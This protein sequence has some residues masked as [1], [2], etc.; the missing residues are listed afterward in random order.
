MNF[1]RCTFV[2]AADTAILTLV[3]D[4]DIPEIDAVVTDVERIFIDPPSRV[5]LDLGAVS[6]IGSRGLSMLLAV[7]DAVTLRGG[8]VEVMDLSRPAARLFEIT[9]TGHLFHTTG[10]FPPTEQAGRGA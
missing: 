1:S 8:H 9:G 10:S 5:V 4:V 3:G 7:Y 2:K 6:F